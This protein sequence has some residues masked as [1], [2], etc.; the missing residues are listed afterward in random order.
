ML[1]EIFLSF[2]KRFFLSFFWGGGFDEGLTLKM[3]VVPQ[4]PRWLLDPNY[5]LYN[6]ETWKHELCRTFSSWSLLMYEHLPIKKSNTAVSMMSISRG[7]ELYGDT[8]MTFL[9]NLLSVSHLAKTVKTSCQPKV[10]WC[11]KEKSGRMCVGVSVMKKGLYFG[12]NTV[13]V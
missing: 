7:P 11:R 12:V 8:C 13:I 2:L 5:Q 3:S 10:C 1:K 4:F 6:L 9:Q